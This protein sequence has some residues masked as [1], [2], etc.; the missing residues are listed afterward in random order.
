MVINQ[1][2][3]NDKKIGKM[4]KKQVNDKKISK[5]SRFIFLGKN[6]YEPNFVNLHEF[7]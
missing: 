7:C 5:L 1:K 3:I 2:Q 6:V 4:T